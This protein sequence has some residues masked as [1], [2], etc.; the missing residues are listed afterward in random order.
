MTGTPKNSNWFASAR[1][2]ML[3]QYGLYSVL[4][5]GE[6]AMNKEQIPPAEYAKLA[7]KFTAENMDFDA[8]IGRARQRWG[9]RYATLTTKH[10]D[11]F[12]LY[13]SALTSL[14][15]THSAAHRDLVAE[16]VE[17]CHK[18]DMK[19][20]LYFSLND[21]SA[22]PNAVDALEDPDE[23]YE[24]FIQYVHGQCRE[25]LSNYGPID[26]L[27]YD[28]WWPFDGEGWRG[29]Q[30]NA[31]ARE[32]QPGILVNSRN[33]VE[34]DFVTPEGHVTAADKM[35]EACMQLSDHWC[36][37]PNDEDWKSSKTIAKLLR[38]AAAGGGNLLLNVPPRGDGSIPEQAVAILD[39][40]GEWLQ[41]YGEAIHDSERFE[42][43]LRERS[44]A[45]SDFIYHGG[46]T[47]KG[48]AFYHHI[49]VW[50]AEYIRI[51]GLEC[52]VERVVNLASAR[53]YPFEQSDD[54]VTVR[55]LEPNFDTT[56]PVVLR[57]ET[58]RP[59]IIYK[60]GGW[61]NPTVAHCR[62]DPLPSEIRDLSAG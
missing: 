32:L 39:R 7:E 12:C 17:A 25:I 1:Y 16:F 21:W 62:Y 26:I 14:T 9:M 37:L 49:D 47:A 44:D 59:P 15:S 8:L 60:S 11:G 53:E 18:H 3:L 41:R 31:M 19:I 51:C 48:N 52:Q 34:G 54:C 28:G 50:P 35:W 13:D 43:N 10:H 57:F 24:P 23:C 20:G 42:L 45:R 56:M 4:G 55:D 58:D 27:W 33:G 40:V 22:S 6:W 46:L 36:Y 29:R 30:L 38:K 2:G 61:R 5:R